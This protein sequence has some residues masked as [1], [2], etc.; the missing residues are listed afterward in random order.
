[1]GNSKN[2]IFRTVP[3]LDELRVFDNPSAED[4]LVPLLSLR[5]GLLVRHRDWI[6]NL[7]RMIGSAEQSIPC[8]TLRGSQ[9]EDGPR[10]TIDLPSERL[11]EGWLLPLTG[12][13]LSLKTRREGLRH[14]H[15]KGQ[16]FNILN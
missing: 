10:E 6:L 3:V 14:A 2:C 9:G 4:P 11:S 1:M 5:D 13:C 8:L 7:K 12:R 15:Q 16:R